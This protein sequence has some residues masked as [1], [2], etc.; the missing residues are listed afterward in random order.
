[1]Y[2]RLVL[3]LAVVSAAAI[4]GQVLLG[5][6]LMPDL[7]RVL[8]WRAEGSDLAVALKLWLGSMGAVAVGAGLVRLAAFHPV[9]QA[10]PWQRLLKLTAAAVAFG[11]ALAAIAQ[12][13][14][15]KAASV[16]A[17]A[18]QV[19][20]RRMPAMLSTELLAALLQL[21]GLLLVLA[22]PVFWLV[23]GAAVRSLTRAT[24][25]AWLEV[26]RHIGPAAFTLALAVVAEVYLLPFAMRWLGILSARN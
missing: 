10:P 17:L 6:S 4:A 11:F 25:E 15:L 23:R 14:G 21:A 7:P 12:V 8:L 26:R 3:L 5:R 19:G 9:R 24:F 2:R 1:L 13:V 18:G 20:R 22:A 16:A